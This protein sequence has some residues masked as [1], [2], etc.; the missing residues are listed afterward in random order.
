M[1]RAAF[2]AS[3][4]L[5]IRAG[6]G[7]YWC[8]RGPR[9]TVDE[10]QITCE[11]EERIPWATLKGYERNRLKGEGRD[12]TKLRVSVERYGFAFPVFVW[13]KYVLDGAGRCDFIDVLER[14]GVKIPPIPI[15]R[16]KAKNKR[17][18]EERVLA[19]SSQYK[20]PT[21]E[22][23]EAFTADWGLDLGGRI[24]LFAAF[25]LPSIEFQSI[26][27]AH[28]RVDPGPGKAPKDPRTKPGDLYQLGGHRL[29]CGD[30]TSEVDVDRLMGG[31]QADQLLS[32]PPYGVSYVGKTEDRMTV[33]NDDLD[34]EHLAGLVMASFDLAYKHSRPGAY[35]YASVPARPIHLVFAE[36][37][38][39]RGVLRQIL[40]WD[41][42]QMVL[43]H[44]EYHYR[45]E[46]ILF[47]WKPGKRHR[48]SDRTRTS[49][50]QAPKPSASREHPTMKPVELW[51]MA[52]RDGSRLGEIVLDLFLGSGTT[53]IAAENLG[54][55]CYGMEISPAY[56]DV[57]VDRWEKFTGAK[58]VRL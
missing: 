32:D 31:E 45:H 1:I 27:R 26:V 9:R 3:G 40:V 47:G 38:K 15:V 58:A 35:W 6:G 22:T 29:L 12:L 16:I 43:G 30:S 41:K 8:P 37:W 23:F 13:K 49:V 34:E 19:V 44:S 18:A 55:R 57:I 20:A 21:L 7:C 46:P 10:L 5:G 39:K 28:E 42:G 14:E 54:R 52:V 53:I 33:E 48:N 51:E 11:T 24:E 17:E 2:V 25:E 50:W 4:R 56:C 36:D